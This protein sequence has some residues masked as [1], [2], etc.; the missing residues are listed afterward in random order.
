M[1]SPETQTPPIANSAGAKP[2]GDEKSLSCHLL[3]PIHLAEHVEGWRKLAAEAVIPNPFYEPWTMLPA[4]QHLRDVEELRFLLVYGP[5]DRKGASSRQELS[6]R[7]FTSISPIA[8]VASRSK[9][10]ISASRNAAV[11]SS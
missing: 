6:A 1:A 11:V 5:P 4:I 8:Q 10:K 9:P 2:R 3:G 7:W